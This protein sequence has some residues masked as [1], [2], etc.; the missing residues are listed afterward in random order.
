VEEKVDASQGIGGLGAKF[1]EAAD[2]RG[3]V[4]VR[5]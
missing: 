1:I 4:S 5:D 2:E 3:K